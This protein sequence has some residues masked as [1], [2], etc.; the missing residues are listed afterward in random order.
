MLLPQL[1]LIK[2][3]EEVGVVPASSK[4]FKGKL[5]L[6]NSLPVQQ[7]MVRRPHFPLKYLEEMRTCTCP[8]C[9]T[10]GGKY[11]RSEEFSCNNLLLF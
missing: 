10:F 1:S 2:S 9:S 7:R 11:E 8:F 6:E 3:L 4:S 5:G